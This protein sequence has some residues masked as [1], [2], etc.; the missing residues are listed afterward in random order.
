MITAR[1]PLTS[2]FAME[3]AYSRMPGL[4]A[5]PKPVSSLPASQ[6]VPIMQLCLPPMVLFVP[7]NF[8]WCTETAA[9]HGIKVNDILRVQAHLSW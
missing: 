3:L 2:T 6:C 1:P 4:Q 9:T 8:I 5:A 7:A